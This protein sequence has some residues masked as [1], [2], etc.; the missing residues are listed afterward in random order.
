[1]L[2]KNREALKEKHIMYN[3]KLVDIDESQ[4]DVMPKSK[5]PQSS[6]VILESYI[7]ENIMRNKLY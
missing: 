4:D 7:K 6:L 2:E 3:E 5:P 1:M